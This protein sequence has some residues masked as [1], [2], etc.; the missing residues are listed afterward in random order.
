MFYFILKSAWKERELQHCWRDD[1]R[2]SA[3]PTGDSNISWPSFQ[4]G[5]LRRLSS[6]L[7]TLLYINTTDKRPAEIQLGMVCFVYSS[8]TLFLRFVWTFHTFYLLRITTDLG[9]LLSFPSC[10][11]PSTFIRLRTASQENNNEKYQPCYVLRYCTRSWI[12]KQVSSV[13]VRC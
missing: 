7:L 3:F 11:F 6:G 8:L 10:S 1:G 13:T 12:Y 4:Q 5:N 9:L 2:Y